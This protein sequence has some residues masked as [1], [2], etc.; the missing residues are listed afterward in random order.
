MEFELLASLSEADR[1]TVLATAP[2]RRY[3]RGEA[4]VREGDPG[5]T[6]HLIAKGRVAVRVTTPSGSV[7]TI[8]VH[9]RGGAFGEQALI[10]PSSRRTATVTALEPVE[11]L[12][13]SRSAFADLRRDHP[14]IDRLLIDVLAAEVRRLSQRL[15]EALY[16]NADKR[17]VRRLLDLDDIY[18][19]VIPLTQD[20]L[21]TM[22]GTTRP[23]ANRVLQGLVSAGLVALSRGR[24]QVL[25][26]PELVHRAR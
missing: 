15:A 25:D 10:D 8:N 26:R 24:F 14:G 17:V 20:D 21:A 18:N 16:D 11:T 2:R 4:I 23:T 19:G 5:D 6:F 1:R 7:A 12:S 9:G 22:A 3:A 13:L